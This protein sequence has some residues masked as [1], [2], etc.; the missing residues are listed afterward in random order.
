MK[1]DVKVSG[2]WNGKAVQV[3]GERTKGRTIWEIGLDI[4]SRTKLL[5]PVDT[6]RLRASYTTQE[7]RRGTAPGGE[8]SGADVVGKPPEKDVVV[9]GTNVEYAPFVENIRPHLQPAVALVQGRALNL[10][11]KNGRLEFGDFL[12]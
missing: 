6:G 10:A 12:K 3:R 9:V 8:A 2:K 1:A 4:E 5:C 7:V 11:L